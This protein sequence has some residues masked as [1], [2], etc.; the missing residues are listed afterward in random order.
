MFKFCQKVFQTIPHISFFE[1]EK[2]H[3][4]HV[5]QSRMLVL[6]SMFTAFLGI[7]EKADLATLRR[8]AQRGELRDWRKR[9]RLAH[10]LQPRRPIPLHQLHAPANTVLEVPGSHD[11]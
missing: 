9:A 8:A 5:G 2:K 6:P 7:Y 11:G 3:D 1:A 10:E 4:V